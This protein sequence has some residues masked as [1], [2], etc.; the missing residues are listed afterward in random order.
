MTGGH[1]HKWSYIIRYMP[2]YFG[3]HGFQRPES[4]KKEYLAINVGDIDEVLDELVKNGV[5]QQEGEVYKVD[6][7]KMGVSKVL[8]KGQVTHA[9]EVTADRFSES[10]K[11]KL[12]KAGGK[13]VSGEG[14]GGSSKAEV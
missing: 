6:V 10:A 4:L 2:D 1:K 8:G 7:N 3:K 14:D 5:A 11:Q 13:A 9:I 12:E